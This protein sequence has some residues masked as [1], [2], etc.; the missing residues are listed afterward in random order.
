VSSQHSEWIIYSAVPHSQ[1]VEIHTAP[2]P[3]RKFIRWNGKIFVLTAGGMFTITEQTMDSVVTIKNGLPSSDIRDAIRWGNNLIIATSRGLVV[4]ESSGKMTII[5]NENVS[6]AN[7]INSLAGWDEIFFSTND[8]IFQFNGDNIYKISDHNLLQINKMDRNYWGFDSAGKIFNIPSSGD[9]I[10]QVADLQCKIF[11]MDYYDA[12]FLIATRKGCIRISSKGEIIDTIATTEPMVTMLKVHYDT[13]FVGGFWGVDIFYDRKIRRTVRVPIRWGGVRDI[14]SIDG[15]Y[16]ICGDG[17]IIDENGNPLYEHLLPE[18]KITGICR[19]HNELWV[20][21]FSSGIAKYNSDGWQSPFR[22]ISPFINDLATD[23]SALWIATDD[24]LVRIGADFYIF[25]KPD[26]LNSNN[27]TTLHY[28]GQFLWAG[29]NRGVCRNEKFGWRQYYISDGLCGD[30]IYGISAYDGTGWIA[31]YGGVTKI[32]PTGIECF[33]RC[34]EA[35]K[36]DWVT[37]I[38]L[39]KDD[40][41]VGTYGGGISRY[42]NNEWE[43]FQNGKII[44]PDAVTVWRGNPIFGTAG[45]GLLMWDGLDFFNLSQKMELPLYEILSIFSDDNYIWVG[46][47]NGLVKIDMRYE[48]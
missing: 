22:N 10:V 8:G 15:K 41:F 38:A 45:Q 11:D 36:N 35:I 20:G 48:Q 1:I 24:G 31:T 34:D 7:Q 40:V 44:N 9:Q 3:A 14:I 30:H 29:T 27:I 19:F 2:K 46:T 28:D 21:T 42:H 23:K 12:K 13:L 17:G 47:T 4:L 16:I 32:A 39:S 37:A 5:K 43:F 26:G 33:R 18:N 25:R 6:S